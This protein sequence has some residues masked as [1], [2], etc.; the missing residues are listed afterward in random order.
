MSVHFSNSPPF[1][2]YLCI[3]QKDL[4]G[5]I[6]ANDS[7]LFLN[8]VQSKTKFGH[9]TEVVAPNSSFIVR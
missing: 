6:A 9:N 5:C 7:I 8:N 3:K 4:S 1:K 2:L